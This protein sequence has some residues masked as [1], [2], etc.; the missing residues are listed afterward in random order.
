MLTEHVHT[1]QCWWNL[2]RARWTCGRGTPEHAD[3]ELSSPTVP[4]AELVDVRDML[5]VH[6]A[7]LREFRLAPAAVERVQLGASRRA[8][9]VD[10]HLGFLCDLLHHH[11]EGEDS[12]LWPPL[13]DRLPSTAITY[14]DAAESQHIEIDAALHR[15]AAAR[16]LWRGDPDESNRTGLVTDLEHLYTILKAHLDLE[17]RALLPLAAA[18]LTGAEWRAIG[19]AAAAA[20]PKTTLVL[21]F[22]MF[23][24]DADPAVLKA[25]L[26]SAP[27]LPRMLIPRI[28]PHVYARRAHQIHGSTRP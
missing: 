11:H 12:L 3:P 23:A 7:M 17:E 26:A 2:E 13:R 24:Y 4:A 10:R 28:A 15:V 5:V 19:D 16:A 22:G 6:Q 20:L 21:A 18:L 8:A 1:S 25:M 14:L 27:P 9:A